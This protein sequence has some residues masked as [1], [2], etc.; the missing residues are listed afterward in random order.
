MHTV[1]KIHTRYSHSQYCTSVVHDDHCELDCSASPHSGEHGSFFILTTSQRKLLFPDSQKTVFVS[2]GSKTYTL[3]IHHYVL[4]LGHQR[5]QCYRDTEWVMVES[6]GQPLT[7]SLTGA[8]S[9]WLQ[10]KSEYGCYHSSDDIE[11]LVRWRR[12]SKL[13][14]LMNA[15]KG[16]WY[17]A[18]LVW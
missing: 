6:S 15:E 3:I 5:H 2:C 8:L 1:V 16:I 17:G 9:K 11:K 10:V 12:G 13:H 14:S 18:V 7:A 4:T